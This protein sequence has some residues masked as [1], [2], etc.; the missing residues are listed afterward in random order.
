MNKLPSY[1][2]IVLCSLTLGLTGCGLIDPQDGDGDPLAGLRGLY[3]LNEG[4]F[5]ANNASLWHVAPDWETV[6][7]TV[8]QAAA[9]RGLGDTGQSLLINGQRLYIVV[10]GTSTLEVLDLGSGE[11]TLIAS[12]DLAGAS[13][14][15]A[16]VLDGKAYVSS[17]ALSGLL[18]IDLGTL[19]VVDTIAVGGL[20]ED[21][22]VLA[23]LV[24]AA[25]PFGPDFSPNDAVVAVDPAGAEVTQTYRVGIGP[26]AL[27]VLDGKLYV[28]RQW[29]SDDF[30]S[31][32]G[33]SMVEPGDTAV[34]MVDW[35]VGSGS[36]IFA[37]DGELYV[38]TDG[39][40]ARLEPSLEPSTVATFPAPLA[41]AYL[42]ATDGAHIIVS[43]YGD[44][45]SPGE[46]SVFEP[47]GTLIATLQVGIGPGAVVGY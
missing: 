29:F 3:V 35:G 42:A 33:L 26:Q 39:G 9:G 43:A 13:P 14:R 34:T 38:A 46:L 2:V 22:Q 47:D 8:Y 16:V 31:F 25:V 11:L 18:V 45:S 6:T 28:S 15:Y 7:P 24:Y 32:R 1:L 44:F 5:G 36:D 41:N 17:W 4:A 23:G 40:A 10:N 37:L 12:L 30:T 19:A 21:V 20:P 27:A